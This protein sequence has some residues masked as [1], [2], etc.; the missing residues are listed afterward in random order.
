M[1][2]TEKHKNWPTQNRVQ[3]LQCLYLSVFRTLS[4]SPPFPFFRSKSSKKSY[5]CPLCL[6]IKTAWINLLELFLQLL[7]SSFIFIPFR[8]KKCRAF[9]WQHF[10]Q[11]QVRNLNCVFGKNSLNCVRNKLLKWH[12]KELTK[13]R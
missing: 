11:N 13:S 5:E 10:D 2:F 3:F 6:E 12:R 9:K 7:L 8:K 4:N 1:R